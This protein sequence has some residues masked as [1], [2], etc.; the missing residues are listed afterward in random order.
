MSNNPRIDPNWEAKWLSSERRADFAW[1]LAKIN[2]DTFSTLTFTN[3]VPRTSIAYGMAWRWCHT[4]SD[5]C[6]VPYN[7]LLIALRGE[8]GEKNGRFHFH[9]L[10]GGTTA[11]NRITLANHS[12][13][14]WRQIANGAIA[15]VR[16]YDSSLGGASYITKC[17]GANDY[18]VGKYN[19]ADQVTLSLSVCKLIRTIGLSVERR[20]SKQMRQNGQ[21]TKGH[22]LYNQE[23]R[24]GALDI[25]V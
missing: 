24:L 22:G 8:L 17:L 11:R 21:V 3:P 18:E 25:H 20:H 4:L 6:S 2:W 14:V 16:E 23:S 1:T 10:M 9:V 12:E 7:R 19:L 13:A 15:E 5:F